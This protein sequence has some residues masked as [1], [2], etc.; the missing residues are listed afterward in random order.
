MNVLIV[1]DERIILEGMRETVEKAIPNANITTC[2]NAKE[3]LKEAVDKQFSIAF[4]DIELPGKSGLDLAKDLLS[5]NAKTNIIFVTAYSNYAYESYDLYASGYLLKPTTL[6][7]VKNA[8]KHLRNPIEDNLEVQCFGNFEVFY[9][10]KPVTFKRSKAKELF[11]Y[12][13][14]RNGAF[15]T[16]GELVAILWEDREV[17]E[18]VQSQLRHLI[19]DIRKTLAEI[20]HADII[21]K[22]RNRIAIETDKIKCDYFDYLKGDKKAHNKYQGEY[23]SQYS[24]AEINP[25]M[26]EPIEY[27]E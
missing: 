17:D 21:V 22:E 14:D 9:N 6:Q 25:I 26:H 11:A 3:A 20:N 12:L 8:L 15:C 2:L 10:H 27:K 18:S 16:M 5:L 1:D 4:L 24:W 7:D 13:I 23:M 19:S